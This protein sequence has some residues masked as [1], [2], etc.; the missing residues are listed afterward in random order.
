MWIVLNK[1]FGII[2]NVNLI[3]RMI[4]FANEALWHMRRCLYLGLVVLGSCINLT[5][6]ID[7]IQEII[8]VSLV[9]QLSNLSSG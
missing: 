7:C 5:A 4:G 3:W 8:L 2:I 6:D 1:N 9:A